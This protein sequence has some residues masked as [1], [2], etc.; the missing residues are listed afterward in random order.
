MTSKP[1]VVVAV[2]SLWNAINFRTGLIGA[3]QDAGWRVVVVAP[4]GEGA[5]LLVSQGVALRPIPI[6]ARGTSP[7]ADA[8]L[9]ADYYRILRAV[10][11]AAFLAFTAKPNIYG[12][13]AARALGIPVINNVAGLGSTFTQENWLTRLMV[14]LYKLAL[15]KSEVV[16]FQNPDDRELFVGRGIVSESQAGLLPGSGVDLDRFQPAEASEDGERGF[17]FLL[18]ARLLWAKG[19]AEYVEAARLVRAGGGEARF[20]MLGFVDDADPASVSQVQLDRWQADQSIEYLGSTSDVRPFLAEADCI[21]LPSYYRE[22]VPRALLEAAATGKPIITTD[23]VGCREAVDDGH[24][25]FL[26][27]PRSAESLAQAMN[28]VLRLSP[29]ERRTMGALGRSKME[30]Q[31]SQRRVHEAY[32]RALQQAGVIARPELP[33]SAR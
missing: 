32:A 33:S 10:R 19:L 18:S 16:F 24:S 20:Q 21:V 3:L 8:R 12:S 26:C 5:E 30:R 29:A 28:K 25:G 23:S 6:N 14:R 7:I 4:P 13:L 27:T 1:V 9:L 11:P 2:N 31:F 15:V 17:T 22:G